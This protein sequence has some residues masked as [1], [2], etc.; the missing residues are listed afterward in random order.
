MQGFTSAVWIE[1]GRIASRVQG[2]GSMKIRCSKWDGGG[3]FDLDEEVG[4][5]REDPVQ[6]RSIGE[7]I[8]RALSINSLR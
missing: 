8:P 4:R 6:G 5:R 2:I 7:G 1:C 3:V